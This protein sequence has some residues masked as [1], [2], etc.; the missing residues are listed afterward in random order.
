MTEA[1]KTSLLIIAGFL[2][3]TGAVAISTNLVTGLICIGAAIGTLV[4]RGI[5]KAKGIPV[6]APKDPEGTPAE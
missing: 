6:E 1:K 5:L 3:T 4:L 2:F